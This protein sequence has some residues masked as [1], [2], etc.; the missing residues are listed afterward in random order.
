MKVGW[1]IWAP[2][3]GGQVAGMFSGP[4][5]GGNEFRC[6]QTGLWPEMYQKVNEGAIAFNSGQFVD[7]KRILRDAITAATSDLH[8]AFQCALGLSAA[9][10]A[11]A[12]A[13]CA[14]QRVDPRSQA[15]IR[16]NQI[17]LRFMHLAMNWL[18]W[19]FVKDGEN[20]AEYVDN[21]VWPIT[22]QQINDEMTVV[23]NVVRQAGYDGHLPTW[24]DVPLDFRSNLK[25]VI[26]SLC[27]YPPGH[28]LTPLSVSNKE[29]YVK[30]FGYDLI[31]ERQRRDEGRPHAWGKIRVMQ[32]YIAE[33]RWDWVV[34]LDCDS[35]FMNVNQTLDSIIFKYGAVGPPAP[36]QEPQLDPSFETLVS[37]DKAMLN[38]GVFFM[39]STQTN[40]RLLEECWGGARSPFIDHPWWEN[41][42]FTWLF[43]KDNMDKFL[44]E[45]HMVFQQHEND[46]LKDVYPSYVRLAPQVEFNSYHPITSRFL[47]DTWEPGKFIMSFSGVQSSSS[48]TVIKFVYSNYYREFCELNA[49]TD[50]CIPLANELPWQ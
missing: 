43:L 7:A 23:Q 3:V 47:H 16:A 2:C 8:V 31:V 42:A 39:K 50:E 38:T 18:T 45:D 12:F 34:W 49:V 35:Y 5:G 33:G 41:A 37:E 27:A 14:D 20:T 25:I 11:L 13:Y 22:I 19:A 15:Y 30:R 48:P 10:R 17:G 46:M 36:G 4:P 1:V 6:P 24:A 29:I 26:V 21:S 9:Y 28:V 40:L 44:N 32:Q